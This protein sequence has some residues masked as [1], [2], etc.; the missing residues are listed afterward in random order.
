M[1]LAFM[2]IWCLRGKWLLLALLVS[3]SEA[4]AGSW[5]WAGGA[6]RRMCAHGAAEAAA[7][8]SQPAL[9]V[10]LML[11]AGGPQRAY[12]GGLYIYALLSAA[13]AGGSLM[14]LC[15]CSCCRRCRRCHHRPTAAPS[16]TLQAYGFQQPLDNHMTSHFPGILA[17]LG[18][19]RE[20]CGALLA[21]PDFRRCA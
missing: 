16:A 20:T 11:P 3:A 1:L 5:G 10:E 9:P 18:L 7:R 19:N 4:P 8:A 15:C 13:A 2:K 14:P 6:G 17:A 21:S 12:K